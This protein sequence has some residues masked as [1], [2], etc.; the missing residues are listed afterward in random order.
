MP[1]ERTEEEVREMRKKLNRGRSDRPKAGPRRGR[2]PANTEA[3]Y[4][5][6]EGV[7]HGKKMLVKMFIGGGVNAEM[8]DKMQDVLKIKKNDR[9]LYDKLETMA[10]RIFYID[11]GKMPPDFIR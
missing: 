2:P 4:A 10:R 8:N 1:V 5:Y 6:Q 7:L 11:N 9:E 3:D